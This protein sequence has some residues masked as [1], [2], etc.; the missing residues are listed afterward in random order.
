MGLTHE[1]DNLWGNKRALIQPYNS[2]ETILSERQKHM[3][4]AFLHFVAKDLSTC[5]GR[6]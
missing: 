3:R 5:S 4:A 2:Q 1:G 6:P